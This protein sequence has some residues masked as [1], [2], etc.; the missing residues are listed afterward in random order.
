MAILTSNRLDCPAD[1]L[2]WIAWYREPELSREIRSRIDRHAA[3]CL[4]CRSE[5]DWILD[6]SAFGDGEPMTTPDVDASLEQVMQRVREHVPGPGKVRRGPWAAARPAFAAA[7]TLALLLG[8]AWFAGNPA[9]HAQVLRTA[10]GAVPVE[11][12]GPAVEVIFRDDATWA[13]IRG[14]VEQ[15]EGVLARGPGAAPGDRVQIA[16][17]SEAARD[18]ALRTLRGSGLTLFAEPSL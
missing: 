5:L 4:A 7:A 8:A 15:V 17:R 11:T 12:A 16:L 1:V 2:E 14:L 10:S 18:Q 6:E 9:D 13:Q 3:E